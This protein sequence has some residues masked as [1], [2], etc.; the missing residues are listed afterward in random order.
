M[1]RVVEQPFAEDLRRPLVVTVEGAHVA[2][3]VPG[4][5]SEIRQEARPYHIA[6]R[7]ER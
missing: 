7:M 3:E 1:P 4:P 5:L 2:H 6:P